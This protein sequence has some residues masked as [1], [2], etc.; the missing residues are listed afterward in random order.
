PGNVRELEHAIEHAVIMAAGPEL[1]E[2]PVMRRPDGPALAGNGGFAVDLTLPFDHVRKLALE[3]VESTYLR[4]LLTI[5]RGRLAAVARAAR[6]NDRTLYEKM[7]QYGLR[8]E[9]FR[10]AADG[11]A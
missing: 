6:I 2:I 5:H 10:G 3:Q 11:D 7:R 9:D 8:K 4:G 1:T